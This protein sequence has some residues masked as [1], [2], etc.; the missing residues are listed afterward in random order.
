MDVQGHGDELCLADCNFPAQSIAE[1]QGGQTSRG[2]RIVYA[3]GTD[4]VQMLEA[5][6][7]L[8]PL[9]QYVPQPVSGN[10]GHK[11]VRLLLLLLAAAPVPQRLPSPGAVAS[12]RGWTAAVAT[13]ARASHGG[14]AKR[15]G[16][17]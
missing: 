10:A 3:L 13:D 8:M 1:A 9:D 15:A 4:N 6:L 5:V 16:E 11:L 7:K 14:T 2:P 12:R 17:Q